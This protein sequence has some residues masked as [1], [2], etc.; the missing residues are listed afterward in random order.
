MIVSIPAAAPFRVFQRLVI[1]IVFMAGA[2]VFPA[3]LFSADRAADEVVEM[4]AEKAAEKAVEK[5]AEEA[6]EKATEKAVEEAVE[7]AAEKV[8]EKA[9]EEAVGEAVEK[10]T[11]KAVEKATE[12]AVEEA[13]EKAAEKVVEKAAEEAAEK[14]ELMARR[15]DEWRGPTKVHF[16]VFVIDIDNIDDAN[17]TFAGNI[18]LRLRWKDKRLA[19]PGGST[20]QIRLEEVWNPQVL[21]AN[22]EGLVSKSLPDVVQ[23][24]P[25]G[26]VLYHQRYTGNLSQPLNLSAF[27]MDAHTFKIHFVAAGYTQYE[28]EFVPDTFRN[29]NGGSISDELS[30]TDWKVVSYEALAVLYQPIEEISGAAFAFRFEA[31]RYV[32]YYIWQIILP[33]AVVVMM[34]WA[35]FWIGGQNVGVRIGVATSSI[36]TLIAHRFVL[37][38]LLPRLPYMTRLDY[39][40]VGSML[41]VFLA[42][43]I[44]VLTSFL[45][46]KEREWLSHKIDIWARATFPAIFLFL[47]GW[48]LYW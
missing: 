48:F 42:L 8:M 6:V 27:P 20:R 35:A 31:E 26:T 37:A 18:Y 16:L 21:L 9:A 43:I 1:S 4:A 12:K 44:V 7:K 5:A 25:D 45:V 40:S 15:P 13:V 38:S 19:N 23:V 3:T 2:C 46:M 41:L 33:L 30:L 39:F 17:Q 47:L 28:L 22:R 36:L 14:A 10:V 29:L 34:S 11:E 24:E 32:A